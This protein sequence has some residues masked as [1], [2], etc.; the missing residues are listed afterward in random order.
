MVSAEDYDKYEIYINSAKLDQNQCI[1]NDG[2]S[3]VPLNDIKNNLKHDYK[4][5]R[6]IILITITSG[7]KSLKVA[8]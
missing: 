4:R 6:S 7:S 8:E 5:R 3:Y 1:C 2:I